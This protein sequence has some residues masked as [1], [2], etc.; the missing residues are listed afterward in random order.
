MSTACSLVGTQDKFVLSVLADVIKKKPAWKEVLVGHATQE[1][2]HA[3]SVHLTFV[4]AATQATRC[5]RN[6]LHGSGDGCTQTIGR[7]AAPAEISH[8]L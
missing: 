5:A 1:V 2:Q 6:C 4:G 8:G 3:S 7:Q